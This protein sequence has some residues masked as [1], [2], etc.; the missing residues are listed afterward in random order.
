MPRLS[1]LA[2]LA[3]LGCIAAVGSTFSAFSST[4]SNDSNTVTAK[5][6]FPGLR[7]T[8][9]W[10]LTDRSSGISINSSDTLSFA[11]ALTRSTGNFATTFSAT[12]YVD[13]DFQA[14][15]PASVPIS[16][17]NFVFR[18]AANASGE[19][20]C[21]YFE[22]H[23]QSDGALLSSYGNSGS[24]IG[25]VTGLTQTTF[26]TPITIP[27]ADVNN[28]TVR[29]FATESGSR[30]LRI[31]QAVVTGTSYGSPW[32]LYEERF[33][34]RAG[35]GA[36]PT[37]TSWSLLAQDATGYAST[38]NWPSAYSATRY[39]DFTFPSDLVPSGAVIQS[40]SLTHRF[41]SNGGPGSGNA[42]AYYEVFDSSSTLLGNHPS[43]TGSQ[44]GSCSA[45]TT[46]VTHT[47]PLTEVTTAA[48]VNGLKVR[49]YIW[50]TGAKKTN[51]DWVQ[52][53]VNY[54][55]D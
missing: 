7:S 40:V 46:A 10:S 20:A 8:S 3:V 25:C 49:A 34:D 44:Y 30:P 48:Q 11:D 27:V 24:T 5:R 12:R 17:G 21:F 19:T 9:A 37:Y 47:V 38:S 18:Y 41:R 51:H 6:I 36:S 22:L 28:L 23:R 43:T 14:S 55:L 26:T 29:V 33:G 35:G 52:L 39:L 31:D 1:S 50:E 2:L 13:L 4:T 53:D 45:G 15:R 16:S 42:C 54:Y 32:T